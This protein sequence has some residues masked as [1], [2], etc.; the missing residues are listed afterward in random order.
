MEVEPLTTAENGGQNFLR[1]GR[2]ENK[3]HVRRRL[4]QRFQERIERGRGQHVHFVDDINLIARL[5]WRVA[6]VVA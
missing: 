6:H 5:R 3:F 4:L 2:R 1:L